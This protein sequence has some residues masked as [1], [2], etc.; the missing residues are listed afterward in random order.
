MAK[1]NN[2]EIIQEIGKVNEKDISIEMK[3]C[4]IDYAMSVIVSRACQMFGMD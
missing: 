2:E 4:Y 3:E 1:K